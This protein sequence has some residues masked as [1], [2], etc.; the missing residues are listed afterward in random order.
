MQGTLRSAVIARLSGAPVRAGYSDPRER[1]ATWFYTHKLPRQAAHVV[2]QGNELL[3]QALASTPVPHF[4]SAP[5][6]DRR[7]TP[8]PPRS[9]G[10]R[11]GMPEKLRER[12]LALLAPG[13]GW[14]AKQWPAAN[15]AALARELRDRG[16]DVAVNAAR[17]DNELANRVV[18]E[19]NGAARLI[20]CNVAG[21]LALTR[22]AALAVGGDT[23]PI[24]LA[25]AL[26]I[27]LVALFGPTDPARNG[28][29]GAG[30]MRVLR[31][32][33]SVTSYKHV[34]AEDPGLARLSVEQVLE[35]ALD[36]AQP[37]TGS[38]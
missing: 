1:Q 23:G 3:A 12:P 9:L 31:D 33:S 19:S 22:R 37:A 32:P 17:R 8:T 14:G 18:V 38:R 15:F 26:G 21:L 27:P 16:F 6:S 35:A 36:M 7:R 20:V 24:H 25:A 34:A 5:G 13:A 10:R 4:R 30:P 29:W 11:L 2:E 28:P